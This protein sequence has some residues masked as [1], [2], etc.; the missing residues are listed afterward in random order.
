MIEQS[1]VVLQSFIEQVGMQP[2]AAANVAQV[3]VVF[4]IFLLAYFAVWAFRQWLIPVVEKIVE[5]T[6]TKWDDYLLTPP[7]LKAISQ[8]IPAWFIYGV[9]PFCYDSTEATTYVALSRLTEAYITLTATW[10][11]YQLLRNLNIAIPA[12]TG[13]YK[14]RGVIQFS[15]VIVWCLGV[16]VMIS[17]L[18]GYNPLRFIAGLGAVATVLMLVFKDTITGLVAGIQLSANGMLRVGDWIQID[19]LGINGIVREISLTTIKVRNFDN[20]MSTIPPYTLV[21]NSFHNWNEMNRVGARRVKRSIYIDLQSIREMKS[22]EIKQLK[23]LNLLTDV[24]SEDIS[25]TNLTAF[26][27]YAVR[28][29]QAN[30]CVAAKEWILV[31]GLDSTP[32]GLPVEFWFYVSETEFVHFEEIASSIIE[33]FIATLPKFGLKVVQSAVVKIDNG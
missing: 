23:T 32:Y 15:I 21:S 7:V 6:S 13:E 9:L 8:L 17:Q 33:S 4:T 31:R 1:R 3:V 10:L 2:H 11:L 16:I 5:H 29:L 30:P 26:R 18:I 14:Y 22:E 28:Q 20:T 12:H 27:R 24:E 19:S 25:F